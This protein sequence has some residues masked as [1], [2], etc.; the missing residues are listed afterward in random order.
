M[1]ISSTNDAGADDIH[2]SLGLKELL[3]GLPPDRRHSV[4]DLGP[5]S[6]GNVRFFSGHWCRLYIADLFRTLRQRGLPPDQSES[7]DRE[8]EATLP[9]GCFD[10]ILCWDLLDYLSSSQMKILGS[11]LAKRSRPGSRM[12]ALIAPH[13]HI[14]DSPQSFEI[15]S[16]ESVRYTNNAAGR[17]PAPGYREPELNRWISPFAVE[18]CYLLRHGIQEYILVNRAALG[19]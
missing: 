5:A 19:R 18:S 17:R 14:P 6:N 3:R 8:L 15:L 7:F 4:L 13:G 10:L 1:P 16:A 11:Q 2:T 9:N 12:F